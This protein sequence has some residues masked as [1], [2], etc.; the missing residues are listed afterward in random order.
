MAKD[1]KKNDAPK[2]FTP[3]K[4]EAPEGFES[5]NGD[6]VGFWDEELEPV[7]FG[8]PLEA[9]MSDSKADSRKPSIL[10]T[11]KI[12][13]DMTV[14]S[15]ADSGGRPV[16]AKAGDLVGVWSRPGMAA[17]KALAGVTVHMYSSGEK[18]TGKPNA[19]RVYEISSRRTASRDGRP[20]Q[21]VERG[22]HVPRREPC[23]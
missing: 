4:I 2:T 16:T 13:K 12:E 17:L 14:A 7:M 8:T 10:I 9:R 20:S 11:F 19:M 1:N 18:D 23:T 5:R 15:S 22:I 6:F 3:R 21:G